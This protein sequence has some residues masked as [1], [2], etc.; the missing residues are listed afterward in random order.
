MI[1]QHLKLRIFVIWTISY[2]KN[3]DDLFPTQANYAYYNIK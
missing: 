1:S 3:D 2:L